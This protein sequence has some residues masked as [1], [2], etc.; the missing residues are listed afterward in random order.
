MLGL[1]FYSS[2]LH[3]NIER[4]QCRPS[5]FL[6]FKLVR[7]P[8]RS[9]TREKNQAMLVAHFQI[10]VEHKD[11]FASLH[12]TKWTEILFDIH[13][14]LHKPAYPWIDRNTSSD[15]RRV[16][17]VAQQR[18]SQAERAVAEPNTIFWCGLVWRQPAEE[19][20]ETL[21]TIQ[22]HFPNR[23]LIGGWVRQARQL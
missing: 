4:R 11:R 17:L 19:N 6:F 3:V 1:P 13:A 22:W 20:T 16:E 23:A 21:N 7:Y 2:R 10:H 18:T 9:L 15:R 12:A 8:T 5:V 14:L